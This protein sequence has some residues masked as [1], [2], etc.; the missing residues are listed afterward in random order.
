MP[1]D[2]SDFYLDLQSRVAVLDFLLDAV[3]YLPGDDP[4]RERAT[5][6]IEDIENKAS[7]STEALASVAR[8]VGRAAWVPRVALRRYLR[9]ADGQREEWRKVVAAVS[10]STAHLLERFRAGTKRDSVDEVLAHEESGTAFRDL[11]RTEINEVRTHIHPL[12]W[13]EKK[14]DLQS[15]AGEIADE[16]RILE[17]K[18]TELR[19]LGFS[20]T[21]I[22]DG[23][24]ASK[25]ARLE[26]RLYFEGEELNPERINEEIKLYREQK[27]MAVE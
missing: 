24:I 15:H 19:D 5:K 4:V 12:M 7:V 8:D 22:D 9:T 6:M 27:E 26:D 13:H 16:L 2:M 17:N 1:L 11:E 21:A 10:N 23:E 25:I 18:I 3:E 20:T 14:K